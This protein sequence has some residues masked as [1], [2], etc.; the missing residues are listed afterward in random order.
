MELDSHVRTNNNIETT[1]GNYGV[2]ISMTA[3]WIGACKLYGEVTREWQIGSSGSFLV[4][5]AAGMIGA[6]V[7]DENIIRNAGLTIASES[8]DPSL[9]EIAKQGYHILSIWNGA[10]TEGHSMGTRVAGNSYQ[11]FDP[12]FGLYHARYAAGLSADVAEHC[13]LHYPALNAE[14]ICRQIT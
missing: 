7:G 8:D 11:F 10:G 6:R 1:E 9:A 13:R 5:Q 12:N 2:C 4:R 14:F 3:Q